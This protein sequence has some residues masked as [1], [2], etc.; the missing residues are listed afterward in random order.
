MFQ[1]SSHLPQE[2]V[3]R[4]ASLSGSCSQTLGRMVV[5]VPH[6]PGLSVCTGI[7]KGRNIVGLLRGTCYPECLSALRSKSL[8]NSGPACSQANGTAQDIQNCFVLLE[9]AL[10]QV[11]ERLTNID[12]V[13]IFST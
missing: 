10:G 5:V 6:P 8:L 3:C 12:G 2:G 4:E 7:A 9:E 1:V 11:L 13:W